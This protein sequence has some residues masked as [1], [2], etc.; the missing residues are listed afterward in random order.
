MTARQL[1]PVVKVVKADP[2]DVGPDIR[3]EKPHPTEPKVV[4]VRCG[5]NGQWLI[6]L[7]DDGCYGYHWFA[8]RLG[9]LWAKGWLRT[10]SQEHAELAAKNAGMSARSDALLRGEPA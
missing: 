4:E 8:S 7:E 5:V 6:T 9:V 1:I 2:N 3:I 10:R